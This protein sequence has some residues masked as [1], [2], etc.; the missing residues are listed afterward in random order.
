MKRLGG[1]TRYE[2]YLVWD[3]RLFALTVA[4]ILRP[5]Q[6]EDER[7]LRELRREAEILER[8]SHPVLV[9]GFDAVLDGA[10]PHVLLEHLEGPTLRRLLRRE[11][12]LPLEQ[13]LPLALHVAAALH[14]VAAERFVHSTSSPATSSWAA[15]PH[16]PQHRPLVRERRSPT[17]ADRDRRVHG[18]GAVRARV[19][20]GT[21]RPSG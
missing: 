8:L 11:G 1:G 6:T 19:S 21:D 7:A 3:E 20:T 9:R 16:R 5:D 10:Y 17:G 12:K 2:V 15:P 14:Y 18:A 4:K 13:V